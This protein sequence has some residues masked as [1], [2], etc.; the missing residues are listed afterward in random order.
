M[1]RRKPVTGDHLSERRLAQH[2]VAGQAYAGHRL[3][4]QPAHEEEVGQEVEGLEERAHRD[5]RRELEDVAA[6]A[7]LGHVLHPGILPRDPPAGPDYSRRR[8]AIGST[9]AARVAGTTQAASA[10]AAIT[11]TAAIMVSGS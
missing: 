9:R 2:Q 10:A 7:A 5:E 8:A 6:D 11:S 3:L 4:A 1:E